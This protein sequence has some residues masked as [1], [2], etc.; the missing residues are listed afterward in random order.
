[1]PTL[2]NFHIAAKNRTYPPAKPGKSV[3][4]CVDNT[5]ISIHAAGWFAKFFAN[6]PTIGQNIGRAEKR[7]I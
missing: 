1:V 5:S 4:F 3:L 6:I 7:K 2:G